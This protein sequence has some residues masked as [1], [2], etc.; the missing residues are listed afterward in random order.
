MPAWTLIGLG[1]VG[2]SQVSGW[3]TI[4]NTSYQSIIGNNIGFVFGGG[5]IT[6]VYGYTINLQ[7]DWEYFVSQMSPE[8]ASLPSPTTGLGQVARGFLGNGGQTQIVYGNNAEFTYYGQSLTV[9]RSPNHAIEIESPK[10]YTAEQQAAY[11]TIIGT[12]SAQPQIDAAKLLVD[13]D[14][15]AL[16]EKIIAS[17]Y[18]PFTL[19]LMPIQIKECLVVGVLGIFAMAMILRFYNGVDAVY[20]SAAMNEQTQ[21]AL[22]ISSSLIS[23][24]EVSWIYLLGFLEM[25]TSASSNIYNTILIKTTADLAKA[26]AAVTRIA[27][28][29]TAKTTQLS[30]LTGS[31]LAVANSTISDLNTQLGTARTT[32][33]DAITANATAQKNLDISVYS[34]LYEKKP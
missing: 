10:L 32:V 8:F 14:M 1:L 11:A 31:A 13:T 19:T 5:M 16:I 3:D 28:A 9:E 29:V 6:N 27:A 22:A 24:L 25:Q 2:G 18:L 26:N 17:G 4:F 12:S 15:Q 34:Y 21:Y 33:G 30:T 20:N 23:Q 7:I